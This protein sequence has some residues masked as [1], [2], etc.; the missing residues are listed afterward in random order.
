VT[1]GGRR[2]PVVCDDAGPGTPPTFQRI[3][4]IG[5]GA[6]GGSLAMAARRAWPHAL[7]IGVDAHD[8]V[9]TAIRL[10]AID[11]GGDDLVLAGE[12]DLVVLAGGAEAN[13]DV[14]PY[15]D[16]AVP[17][18]AVVLV[19]GSR[20]EVQPAAL[21]PA[22]LPVVAAVPAV[23]VQGR[24]IRAA[25]ADLFRGRPWTMTPVTAGPDTVRRVQGFLRAIGGAV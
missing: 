11:V 8:A 23:H 10:H 13:A 4:I 17:G 6:V 1:A 22:R 15:L 3:A 21:L 20:P 25:D 19:L 2:L 7:V 18:D 16:A 5:L 14:L 24:G 9:E 12:A